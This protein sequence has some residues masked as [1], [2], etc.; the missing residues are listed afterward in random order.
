[1]NEDIK[2]VF[3][4]SVTQS[5]TL[6]GAENSEFPSSHLVINRVFTKPTFWNK[7]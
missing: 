1:M 6:S 4:V 3:T 7:P 5:L 2:L